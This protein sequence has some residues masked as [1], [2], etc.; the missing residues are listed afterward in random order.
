[1]FK[2]VL[3]HS[4]KTDLLNPTGKNNSSL[5]ESAKLHSPRPRALRASCPTYSRALRASCPKCSR[6]SRALCH[7]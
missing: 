6:A 4:S 5:N 3:I 7:T 2:N 1:M